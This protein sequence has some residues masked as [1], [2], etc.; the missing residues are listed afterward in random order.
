[1]NKRIYQL[2]LLLLFVMPGLNAQ[3]V[4]IHDVTES[5]GVILVQIDMLDFANV[6]SI[7]LIIDYDDDLLLFGGHTNALFPLESNSGNG[8]ITIGGFSMGGV[9]LNGKLLDLEFYYY[10]GFDTPLEFAAGCEITSGLEVIPSVFLDGSVSQVTTSNTVTMVSPAPVLVGNTATIPIEIAGPDFTAVNAI[11]LKVAYDPDQLTYTG[12]D[13][14]AL[15]GVTANA[16]SGLLTLQWED[17]TAMNFTSLTTLLDINFTYNGGGDAPLEFFAGCEITFD[18]EPFPVNFENALVVPMVSD[19]KLTI[20]TVDGTPGTNVTLSITASD[21]DGWENVVGAITLKIGFDPAQLTYTGYAATFAGWVGSASGGILT[22][23]RSNLGGVTL[24][25]NFLDISFNYHGGGSAAVAFTAGTIIETTDLIT[26]P[27]DLIN[28]AVNPED[29]P[30][31]L[32]LGQVNANTGDYVQVPITAEGFTDDVASATLKIGFPA[33]DLVYTGFEL[34]NSN[35]TGFT[36]KASSNKVNLNWSNTDGEPLADGVLLNLNF[37]YAGTGLA[38]VVFNP[39]VILTDPNGDLIPIS[40]VDGYVN[41]SSG[42]LSLSIRVFLEGPYSTGTGE[43]NT[44]LQQNSILPN[45]QPYSGPPWNFNG[46][47]N[48][49]SVPGDIVDWV[50]VE[51]RDAGI[52]ANATPATTI[53]IGALFL[54][55]DGYLVDLDGISNPTFPVGGIDDGLFIIVRH[56]N[57]MDVM[58]SMHMTLSGTTYSY[59]FTDAASKAL[60][61]SNGHK[62]LGATVYGMMSGDANGDGNIG[63]GDFTV[64]AAQSGLNNLYLNADFTLSGNVG[65]G[66]FLKWTQNSGFNNPILQPFNELNTNDDFEEKL[67][68]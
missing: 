8:Q 18:G 66:D 2:I 36:A 64:W 24:N 39:G 9:S 49:A 67:S 43:M 46:T 68:K 20:E 42:A 56:R 59:D 12:K 47:E 33:G 44:T 16:G 31:K 22:L 3:T 61:G 4:K 28:G 29:H 32:I 63:G 62:S 37:N 5:P 13:E 65:G 53:W 11:T 17:V 23:Q 6:G 34:V 54:N 60:N 10:G 48:V 58:S 41:T 25:G 52:P 55:K 26:I 30:S 38:P 57:H 7:S 45:T 19:A 14:H 40:M 15:T 27:V 1:M 50:L 51:L 21:F 35:F